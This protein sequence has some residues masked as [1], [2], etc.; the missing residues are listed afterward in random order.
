MVLAR[1]L[2]EEEIGSCFSMGMKSQLCKVEIPM[3]LNENI[4]L[5]V[6]NTATILVHRLKGSLRASISCM[7]TFLFGLFY[8]NTKK[9][10]LID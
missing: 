9:C 3:H 2:G 5:T 8:H 1:V 4:A 6:N 10:L 7:C